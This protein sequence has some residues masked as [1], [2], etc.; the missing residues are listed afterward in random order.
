[1][2]LNQIQ[3]TQCSP[4]ADADRVAVG[5]IGLLGAGVAYRVA[6]VA[7]ALVRHLLVGRA[8]AQTATC[9][10]KCDASTQHGALQLDAEHQR[11][12]HVNSPETYSEYTTNCMRSSFRQVLGELVEQ[13]LAL[14]TAV[15]AFKISKRIAAHH[16]MSTG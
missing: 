4:P 16:Q 2:L 8:T 3:Q 10:L 13:Q 14:A 12:A 5:L 6:T 15:A 1:M 7:L 9:S 11:V